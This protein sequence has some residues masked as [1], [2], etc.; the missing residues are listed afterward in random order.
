MSDLYSNNDY[1]SYLEH[2]SRW[3]WSSGKNPSDYNHD[4]Y[5]RNKEKWGVKAG[6][7]KD[8]VSKG[9]DELKDKAKDALGYD[10]RE[11]LDEAEANE[12]DAKA[13]ADVADLDEKLTGSLAN[14]G[15]KIGIH[16]PN[17]SKAHGN[18]VNKSINAKAD[19]GRAQ[20][21]KNN[22]KKAYDRTPLGK[23]DSVKETTSKKIGA[24]K[25][26]TSEQV[27]SV[28]RRYEEYKNRKNKP[29]TPLM[30]AKELRDFHNA[31]AKRVAE[32]FGEDN[33]N[34]AWHKAKAAENGGRGRKKTYGTG[35]GNAQVKK[36]KS[37]SANSLPS[38]T[39]GTGSK[40][41]NTKSMPSASSVKEAF[42]GQESKKKLSAAKN[43]MEVAQKKYE[44][45]KDTYEKSVNGTY[46]DKDHPERFEE[47]YKKAQEEFSKAI[48][49]FRAADKAYGR[50]AAGVKDNGEK[51]I[52][53][54][55]EKLTKRGR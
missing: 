14:L 36:D 28:K 24:A 7:L 23:V 33:P 41:A 34:V 17:V 21:A 31:A 47:D 9:L 48:S 53:D 10:E 43:K 27:E 22:A 44:K 1:R 2:K 3:D 50:T 8:K 11:A 55:L 15:R 6:E 26:V 13:K 35:G 25:K 12:K 38:M 32:A 20:R 4:Y 54:A 37:V 16:D 29:K 49:E 40:D 30:N 39:S 51:A 45:A 52:K 42:T 5:M 19:Y 46:F 18:A